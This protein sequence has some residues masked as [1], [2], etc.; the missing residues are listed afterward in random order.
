MLNRDKDILRHISSYCEQIEMAE[1]MFGDSFEI[2]DENPVYRNA[3]C[4]CILQIGEL[5]GLLS[6]E[7]KIKNNTIPWRQIKNMRNIAAHKYGSF[8]S[9][10]T[11]D[12]IK[13]DI[14]EL[15]RFCAVKDIL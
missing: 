4:M 5:V 15:K 10:I 13:N 14:P 3:V 2:F 9:A 8:D 12:V 7:F 6:D 1:E 11:W